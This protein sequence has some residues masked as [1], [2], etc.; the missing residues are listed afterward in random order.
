MATRGKASNM[1]GSAHLVVIGGGFLMTFSAFVTH[2][3]GVI[4]IVGG[5]MHPTPAHDVGKVHVDGGTRDRL[6]L[7]N[8]CSN[9]NSESTSGKEPF[10]KVLFLFI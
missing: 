4:W 3:A 5:S 1:G 8:G 9:D 7:G 6:L 10:R 2:A